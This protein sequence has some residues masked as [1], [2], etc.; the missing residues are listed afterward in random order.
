VPAADTR[1]DGH[2]A[3]GSFGDE[4]GLTLS[5]GP[6]QFTLLPEVG[7][8]GA[9]LRHDGAEFLDLH[10]GAD[11]ARHQH[12]TGLPLLAPWANRLGGDEYSALGREVELRGAPGLHRDANGLP[13]HGT[14]VGR[15]G[16]ELTSV[17]SRGES[18]AAV[19]RFRA[20]EDAEV[21]ASF[22]FPHDLTVTFT[23]TPGQLTVATLLVPSGARAVPVSFG[24]HPYFRLA[25]VLRDDL[26]LELPDRK[27]L[28][29]DDRQLPTGE[30]VAEPAETVVL[31][32]RTFDDGYRLGRDRRFA[33]VGGGRRLEAVF[34][35][36]YPYAQVYAPGD[37][38]YVA[39]EPMT[40]P[41]DALR[42]GAAPV[43]EPGGRY[44]ARYR[45]SLT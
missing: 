45:V 21:M 35:R 3:V 39:L 19:A 8:L 5:A 34:E 7:L 26:C 14:L 16:W 40:A 44:H 43:V 10:G 1:S 20:G 24:W 13:M 25:D 29:V 28:L 41:T 38:D 15:A 22:P 9:S 23:V 36:G 2:V 32:G 11:A 18:A 33:L 37:H 12:T 6:T 42:R 30:K 4:G 17:R 31:A 27:H